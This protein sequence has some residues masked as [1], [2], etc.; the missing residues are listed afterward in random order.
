MWE[1]DEEDVWH[2]VAM[3]IAYAM[4]P[5]STSSDELALASEVGI[6]C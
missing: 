5:V 6:Q 1:L 3:Y 4:V 2:T